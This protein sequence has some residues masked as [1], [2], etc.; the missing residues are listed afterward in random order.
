M[1]GGQLSSVEGRGFSRRRERAERVQ[2]GSAS[3]GVG[4]AGARSQ[5]LGSVASLPHR[6]GRRQRH[7]DAPPA[8]VRGRGGRG[9]PDSVRPGQGRCAKIGSLGGLN[10]VERDTVFAVS[11]HLFD[12]S[13]GRQ[14]PSTAESRRVR[15]PSRSESVLAGSPVILSTSPLPP[16]VHPPGATTEVLDQVST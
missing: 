5:A 4:F 15:A 10:S 9:A 7:P 1:P 13:L 3:H 11:D 2:P 12:F 16:S 8:A 14:R 6:S